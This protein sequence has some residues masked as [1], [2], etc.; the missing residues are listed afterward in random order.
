MPVIPATAPASTG[1]GY[2]PSS[3]IKARIRRSERGFTDAGGVPQAGRGASSH[4][5]YR[6]LLADA[7][8]A[9]GLYRKLARNRAGSYLLESAEQG[10]W[11]RYSFVG[12]RAAATL[13]EQHGQAIWLGHAPVGLPTGGDPLVAVRETLRLLHTPHG[14]GCRPSPPAWL[15]ISATTRYAGWNAS[16]IPVLTT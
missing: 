7:E 2:R 6:R 11:S 5:V 12:V 9:I 14:E 1:A 3:L 16:L 10:V 4:P 13:T 8:T 15:V